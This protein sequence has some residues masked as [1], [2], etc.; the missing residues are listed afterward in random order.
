MSTPVLKYFKKPSDVSKFI[1]YLKSNGIDAWSVDTMTPK[2][3]V[4]S[5]GR[6]RIHVHEKDWNRACTCREYYI[7]HMSGYKYAR[8]SHQPALTMIRANIMKHLAE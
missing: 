8:E 4:S 3:D 7:K 2:R 1:K 6:Y 5:F